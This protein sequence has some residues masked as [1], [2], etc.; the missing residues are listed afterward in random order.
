MNTDFLAH[1]SHLNNA[2]KFAETDPHLARL[3]K[4]RLVPQSCLSFKGVDRLTKKHL[5]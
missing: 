1:N 5:N 4:F 3:N 2:D